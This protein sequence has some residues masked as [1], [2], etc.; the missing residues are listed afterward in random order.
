MIGSIKSELYEELLTSISDRFDCQ[1][2]DRYR[3]DP[4]LFARERLSFDPDPWQESVLRWD[5]KRL[6]LNCSR[7]SGK[8]TTTAILALHKAL[9]CSGSLTLLVSPSLRQ[10]SELFRKVT[11][12]LNRLDRIPT[13][14][15]NNK[16]SLQLANESRI[17]SLPGSEATIRG[18]SGVDL[19]IEDEA[20]RVL[21]DLYYSVRPML[22]VS[23]GS[24]VLMST[25][26]G[27]RG[28]FFHE[29]TAGGNSWERV[30]IPANQCPR[31]SQEFLAEELRAIGQWWFDQEYG[32]QFKETVDQ[33]FGYDLIMGSITTEVTPLFEIE[34]V[35]TPCMAMSIL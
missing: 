18:Y 8:S 13:M 11:D 15:E 26:F 19:I 24:L 31:I 28:H 3:D 1:E 14:T 12:F 29:W 17:V 4:V 22:A 32:C 30:E 33:V 16:L 25:P 21:D 23:G 34:E 2:S 27:K 35:K 20:A 10:S 6:L 9:Y 7:Q 5:K